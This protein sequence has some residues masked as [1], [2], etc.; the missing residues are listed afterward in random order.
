MGLGPAIA[1][2]LKKGFKINS[3]KNTYIDESL[4]DELEE[5]FKRL[6]LK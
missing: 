5:K 4:V 2:S 6:N 1:L 3:F